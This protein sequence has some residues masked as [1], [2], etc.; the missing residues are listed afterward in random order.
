MWVVFLTADVNSWRLSQRRASPL[1]TVPP[2]GRNEGI[3]LSTEGGGREEGGQG[4]QEGRRQGAFLQHLPNTQPTSHQTARRS[5][6]SFLPLEILRFNLSNKLNLARLKKDA[7]NQD[8]MLFLYSHGSLCPPVD[9]DII[10]VTREMMGSDW[11]E[12][13]G[14]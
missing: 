9:H 4:E 5:F 3:W 8:G 11:F 10:E 12:S 6:N 7:V 2:A 13:S 14:T 1:R